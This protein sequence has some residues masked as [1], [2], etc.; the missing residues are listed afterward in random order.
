MGEGHAPLGEHRVDEVGVGS[1]SDNLGSSIAHKIEDSE[2]QGEP[3]DPLATCAPHHLSSP[4][5][6]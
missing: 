6:C 4:Q 1:S 2:D 5:I 3:L